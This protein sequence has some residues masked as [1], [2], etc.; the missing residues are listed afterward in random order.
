MLS[1]VVAD[2]ETLTLLG[3][4]AT[5]VTLVALA[6]YIQRLVVSAGVVPVH[7]DRLR[8]SLALGLPL[9]SLIVGYALV[10]VALAVAGPAMVGAAL[11]VMIVAALGADPRNLGDKVAQRLSWQ[12]VWFGAATALFMGGMLG[13]WL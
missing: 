9:T 6:A 7:N 13:L 8:W 4:I 2:S 11:S 12:L 10:R 5:F 1:Q 3:L